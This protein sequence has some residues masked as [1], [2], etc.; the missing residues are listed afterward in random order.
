MKITEKNYT[1]TTIYF[2][3]Q[4]WCALIEQNRNGQNYAGRYVFGA[5]PSNPRLLHWMTYEFADIPLIA[6]SEKPKI[7]FKKLAKD[8]SEKKGFIPKSLTAFSK[9]QKEYTEK[10]KAQNR[11]QK[12]LE[13]REKYLA[14]KKLKKQKG[15]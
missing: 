11:K 1:I 9:A 5:E 14:S 7:R 2:D 10:R 4:F 15:K 13:A 6:V 3:G 12:K 8:N